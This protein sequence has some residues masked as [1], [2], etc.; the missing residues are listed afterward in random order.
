MVRFHSCLASLT[1]FYFI[2]DLV[3]EER[4]APEYLVRGSFVDAAHGPL[5]A[6]SW[7]TACAV[8]QILRPERDGLPAGP[9][10]RGGGHYF[11][12]QDSQVVQRASITPLPDYKKV[13]RRA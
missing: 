11:G 13:P 3:G 12:G 5:A 6:R 9:D 1:F 10:A 2:T 4:S 8:V 7:L